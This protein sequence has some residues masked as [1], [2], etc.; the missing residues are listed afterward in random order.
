V[1]RNEEKW[2]ESFV[3]LME[4]QRFEEAFALKEEQIPNKLFR[5]RPFPENVKDS[6]NTIGELLQRY[7]YL[8]SAD[9][10]DD[11]GE[12]FVRV[13][14]L[15]YMNSACTG[16][17]LSDKV[18]AT[19]C[20]KLTEERKT[21]ARV[22]VRYCCFAEGSDVKGRLM[23][24]NSMMWGTYADKSK[25]ICIEYDMTKLPK[26]S[27]LRRF[28]YPV[29]YSDTPYDATNKFISAAKEDDG[30]VVGYDVLAHMFKRRDWERQREWR[31]IYGGGVISED[32]PC[33]RFDVMSAVYIGA[34]APNKVRN[35]LNHNAD[36]IG[37]P[38]FE[39]EEALDGLR[40]RK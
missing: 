20:N 22:G 40:W 19:A 23:P 2:T 36:S 7:V 9:K 8:T 16:D 13:D 25:G 35:V 14:T 11:S 33:V 31:L 24:A 34:N 37:V 1:S 27:L 3:K 12:G 30:S 10:V 15:R 5:Y 28:M 39:M 17:E 18:F 29:V 26:Q 4:G 32:S 6:N 21:I 38:I